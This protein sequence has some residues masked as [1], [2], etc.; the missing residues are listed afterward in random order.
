MRCDDEDSDQKPKSSYWTQQLFNYEA[1]DSARFVFI[2][3]F[4]IR[5]PPPFHH[6]GNYARNPEIRLRTRSGTNTRY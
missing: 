3:L 4:L 5:T 2:C 6:S 1:N